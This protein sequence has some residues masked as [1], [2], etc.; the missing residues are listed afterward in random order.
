MKDCK[1]KVSQI[2]LDLI[3]EFDKL[4]NRDWNFCFSIML[5]IW[6]IF[7]EAQIIDGKQV[8]QDFDDLVTMAMQYCFYFESICKNLDI[9]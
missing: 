8:I 5:H 6:F 7:Q 4:R 1:K 3:D 2:R 9:T